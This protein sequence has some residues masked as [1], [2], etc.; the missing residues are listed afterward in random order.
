MKT[1]KIF[2]SLLAVCV[3]LIAYAV[4]G[5][6][7]AGA[8]VLAMA[9]PAVTGDYYNNYITTLDLQM[10]KVDPALF[11]RYGDQG[12]DFIDMIHR[13]G[14][15]E[16]SDINVN[17]HY[18]EE[19]IWNSFKVLTQT[20]VGG[21]A[22]TPAAGTSVLITLDPASVDANNK[23]FPQITDQVLFTSD[24]IAV[25][26]AINV[27]TPAAP[28]L[29]VVPIDTSDTI[30]TVAAGT[31]LAIVT[32]I[33]S[34]GSGQPASRISGIIKWFNNYQTIKSLRKASGTE[35]AVTSWIQSVDQNKV[36][37]WFNKGLL[38]LEYEQMTKLQGLFLQGKQVNNPNAV[39][40]NNSNASLVGVGARGLFPEMNTYAEGYNYTPG[41]WEMQDYYNCSKLL[42][43]KYADRFVAVFSGIN[44]GQE[45]DQMLFELN[46]DTGV[47]WAQEAEAA[48][49]GGG[50][51]G[52]TQTMAI[53]FKYVKIDGIVYC[54]KDVD[55]FY[56]PKTYG[57]STYNYQQRAFMIPLAQRKDPK[58]S[59]SIPTIGLKYRGLG[60]FSRRMKVWETGA[61]A[62][63]MPT[64][65]NDIREVN[66]LC[67]ASPTF[68]GSN[69][70]INIKPQ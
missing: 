13:L 20:A 7:T 41:T 52:R 58:T 46:K 37:T 21:G 53:G 45:Q 62:R 36:G 49:F 51:D 54:I 39:D 8:V 19:W 64:D 33:A 42:K 60:D 70:F 63:P 55:A 15:V 17:E 59:N 23:Y 4:S 6:D 34:E 3:G 48:L 61:N 38:D 66:M 12:K 43:K 57:I 18:E 11:R 10:R 35:L 44:F 40:G 65:K 29:T 16:T 68:F 56:N 5:S 25:I 30:P 27:T 14:F 32:N 24:V 2:L 67:E 26:T 9:Q 1:K 22:Y 28:V 69:R 31:D 47:I 50:E